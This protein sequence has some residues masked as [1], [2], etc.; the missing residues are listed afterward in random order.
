MKFRMLTISMICVVFA[1]C[2]ALSVFNVSGNGNRN[3]IL[4][5]ESL[6]R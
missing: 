3:G 2:F 6:G 1:V 4:L 5:V